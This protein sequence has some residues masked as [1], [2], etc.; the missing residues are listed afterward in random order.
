MNRRIFFKRLV[1]GI[2]V[3]AFS[4][5]LFTG[6][7]AEK[8]KKQPARVYPAAGKIERNSFL[9]DKLFAT[10]STVEKVAEGFVHAVG[11]LDYMGTVL[12]AD[13]STNIIYQWSEERGAGIFQVLRVYS[14]NLGGLCGVSALAVDTAGKILVAHHGDRRILRREQAGRFVSLAEYF[15]WLRFNGPSSI[16]VKSNG[17]VYFVDPPFNVVDLGVGSPQKEILY[18]G[19]Y[20]VTKN[21]FVDLLSRKVECPMSLAFSPNESK[22][23]VL[24][25]VESN[26]VILEFT[27]RKDGALEQPST[28]LSLTNVMEKIKPSGLS[29]DR[30]GNLYV[31]AQVGV[32]VFSPTGRY[33][34][35][36][37]T[38]FPATSCS[39]DRAGKY[40]YITT[41]HSLLRVAT[42]TKK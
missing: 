8:A 33:L 20:R 5:A 36:I 26:P 14:T 34:G 27:V 35:I 9:L 29:V 19:I 17:E 41:P 42:S 40:L 3:C 16:A 15:N 10:N 22:L 39:L 30:S 32:L 38:E 28:F 2:V 31:S 1:A 23:Y 24:N 11:C 12:V 4:V 7:C 25:N 13:I 18:N 37:K 6:F 21:G